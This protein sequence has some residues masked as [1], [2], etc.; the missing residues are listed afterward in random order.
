MNNHILKG[1]L[2]VALFSIFS[3]FAVQMPNTVTIRVEN[4]TGK[5]YLLQEAKVE[6][7]AGNR[8]QIS[9]TK[10]IAPLRAHGNAKVLVSLQGP[11]KTWLMGG[12][13][14]YRAVIAVYNPET[15]QESYIVRLMRRD[16]PGSPNAT[17]QAVLEDKRVAGNVPVSSEEIQF[18]KADEAKTTVN[19]SL[20]LF[21][22]GGQLKAYLGEFAAVTH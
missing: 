12:E 2:V 5:N 15:G 20:R 22:E 13:D 9:S 3:S 7:L 4:Q 18:S 10:V 11:F 14:N 6:R 21:E 17:I 19:I 16:L 8:E 1:A